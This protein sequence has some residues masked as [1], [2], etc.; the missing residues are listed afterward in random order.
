MTAAAASAA[1]AT[2]APGDPTAGLV[3]RQHGL[4]TRAQAL[5]AGLSPDAIDRRLATRRW[6]P[7][8][9]RVYRE[10]SHPAG[11]EQRVRAAVL[12]AGD[13]AVL[14]GAAAV[15]WHGLLEHAPGGPGAVTA[16]GVTVPRRR[17]PRP[18]AGVVVRRRELDPAD[19]VEH[20]GVLV[21]AP[22]LSVLEACT[23]LPEAAAT[24]LLQRVLT[25][26]GALPALLAAQVRNLGAHG[27]GPS[28]RLLTAVVRRS[29]VAALVRLRGALT[30]AGVGGWTCGHDVAGV[31]PALAF[32]R[33]RLAVEFHG[34]TD[35]EST[36]WRRGV[37][38]RHGWRV[39]TLDP[40]DPAHRPAQVLAAVRFA[41]ADRPRTGG[42]TAG[43]R[44]RLPGCG[45]AGAPGGPARA[46]S[47]GSSRGTVCQNTV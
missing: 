20:R 7:V 6:V 25:R 31:V 18:R 33:A 32:P 22:A 39:L 23:E 35:E 10:A 40:A 12:W 47:G 4:V 21:T 9:P 13:G 28:G 36:A 34:A 8:H 19:V 14:C 46:A 26:P 29:G 5:G 15:W 44:T 3:E 11:D 38:R 17:A 16:V 1:P 43:M 42:A 24:A 30:E 27:S 2:T 41:V 45:G 37:L